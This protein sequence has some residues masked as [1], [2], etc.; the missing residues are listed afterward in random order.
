MLKN[1][2]KLELLWLIFASIF[3]TVIPICL[4]DTVLGIIS[5]FTG[6]VFVIMSAKGSIWCHVWGFISCLLYAIISYQN[7]Y[8]GE[9]VINILYHVPIQ[10]IGFMSWKKNMKSDTNTVQTRSLSN[11][12]KWIVCAVVVLVTIVWGFC[13]KQIG[14]ALPYI[15]ALSNV[16]SLIARFL[17]VNRYTEQWI[18]WII[19][20]SISVVMWVYALGSGSQNIGTLLMWIIYVINSVWGYIKWKKDSKIY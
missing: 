15:A 1:W 19:L 3:V 7:L 11:K 2:S 17:S 4:G 14:G 6:V 10:V 5:A 20:N 8:Y 16:L 18:L 13:L 9:F 12:N